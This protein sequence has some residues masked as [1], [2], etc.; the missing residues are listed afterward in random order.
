[1]RRLFIA[2][3]LLCTVLLLAAVAPARYTAQQPANTPTGQSPTVA[4]TPAAQTGQSP[5]PSPAG[6]ESVEI[7]TRFQGSLALGSPEKRGDSPEVSIRV[8]T[9]YDHQRIE[10]F[11]EQGFIIAHLRAGELTTVI[12]GTRQERREDE[13]WTVPEGATMSIETDRDTAT[14]QTWAIRKAG[15]P[16]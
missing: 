8:W 4:A 11:S 2:P 16:Q 13:F 3:A 15:K 14:L 10:R 6:K 9:I 1:M 5:S 12:N 7:A